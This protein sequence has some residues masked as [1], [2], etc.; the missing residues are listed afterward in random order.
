MI[1]VRVSNSTLHVLHYAITGLG[2]AVLY[3]LTSALPAMVRCEHTICD[4]R[5]LQLHQLTQQRNTNLITAVKN[6]SHPQQLMFLQLKKTKSSIYDST[7][8]FDVI[9]AN[10]VSSQLILNVYG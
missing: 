2:V 5:T 6:R 1:R 10:F 3:F 4:V 8:T 7:V 9:T